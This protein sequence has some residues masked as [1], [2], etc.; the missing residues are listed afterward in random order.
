MINPETLHI[1]IIDFGLSSYFEDSKKLNT[2]V[3]TPYYVAPEVLDKS[4]HKECDVWSIG[5]ITYVLLT[6]C[7]PFQG[8]T[9]PELFKR[10]KQCYLKYMDT[11]W[12]NLSR[13]SYDFVKG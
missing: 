3:G 12:K 4:Y 6:G 11:D 5:V 10:I 13:E 9:L 1:K 2:K 7:P 8:K